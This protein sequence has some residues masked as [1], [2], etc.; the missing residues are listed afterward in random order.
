MLIGHSKQ[1]Y[2]GLQNCFPD[3]N[4][5][6]VITKLI[7]NSAI[8][9]PHSIDYTYLKNR[10]IKQLTESEYL[11]NQDG[12]H[13]QS[14]KLIF[15]TSERILFF[16]FYM[17]LLGNMKGYLTIIII[18][19]VE[20]EDKLKWKTTHFHLPSMAQK[21]GMLKLPHVYRKTSLQ[22]WTQQVPWISHS[23]GEINSHPPSLKET[24]QFFTCR[25]LDLFRG[26]I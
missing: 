23:N 8:Q 22:S 19:H 16:Q 15:S 24:Y 26:G 1:L 5:L 6:S 21:H 9:K 2:Q 25:Q 20:C 10:E 17:H 7:K 12:G 3:I 14:F 13:A 18:I 11:T 4:C